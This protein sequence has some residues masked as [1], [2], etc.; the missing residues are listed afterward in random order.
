[1]SDLNLTAICARAEAATPPP[2]YV[3][4]VVGLY[5]L[6]D[7]PGYT[8]GNLLS[9]EGRSEDGAPGVGKRFASANAKFCRHAREDVPALVAEVERLRAELDTVKTERDRYRQLASYANFD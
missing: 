2:W 9:A 7:G 4:P 6:L 3:V 1:M 5:M 8:D